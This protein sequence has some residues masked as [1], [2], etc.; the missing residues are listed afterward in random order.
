MQ[1]PVLTPTAPRYVSYAM[2]GAVAGHEVSHAFDDQGEVC[3]Y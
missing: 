3:G 1:Y 2:A